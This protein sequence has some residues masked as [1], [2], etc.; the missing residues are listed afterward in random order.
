VA[1][2]PEVR[3]NVEFGC[4]VMAIGLLAGLAGAAT[5]LLLNLV[6]HLTYHYSFG[7]LLDGVSA[8]SPVR[9]AL[10]PMIGGALAGLGWWLLRRRR[11]VPTVS[12]AITRPAPLPRRDMA[13]VPALRRVVLSAL[14]ARDGADAWCRTAAF[15]SLF[16]D[17]ATA[18]VREWLAAGPDGLGV[19]MRTVLPGLFAQIARRGEPAAWSTPVAAIAALTAAARELEDRPV[20]RRSARRPRRR[21]RGRRGI[22][23]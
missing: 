11:T 14:L 12:E 3:R 15:T 5:T 4:A 8:S 10:G 17:G 7:S 2:H 21:D 6:E 9:R 1:N 19:S 18:I 13:A 20:A 23:A 22:T 16:G